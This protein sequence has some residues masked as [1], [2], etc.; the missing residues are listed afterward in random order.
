MKTT[1]KDLFQHYAIPPSTLH[2]IVQVAA[3]DAGWKP[4][5]DRAE[6]Q[7]NKK[8][9]GK[10]SGLIRAHRAETRR[11]VIDIARARLT[12]EHRRAP[13]SL[14]AIDAL[15]KEYHKLLADGGGENCA[16]LAKDRKDL[17]LLVPLMLEGLSKADQQMLKTVSCDT[18]IKDL[19]LQ[20]KWLTRR[21]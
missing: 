20:R 8:V 21:R 19:K 1:L 14:A 2:E 12:P 5:W 18:L 6:Q 17:C 7:I 3:I 15:E 10:R 9:A 4:P 16:S 11:S 13:Y